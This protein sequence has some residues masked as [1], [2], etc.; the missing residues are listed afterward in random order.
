MTWIKSFFCLF[1]SLALIIWLSLSFSPSLPPS[2]CFSLTL[3]PFFFCCDEVLALP[4]A[5]RF[6]ISMDGRVYFYFF[7]AFLLPTHRLAETAPGHFVSN[8]HSLSKEKFRTLRFW[9]ASAAAPVLC[10]SCC[11]WFSVLGMTHEGVYY[12]VYI[13]LCTSHKWDTALLFTDTVLSYCSLALIDV[14][15]WSCMSF[16]HIVVF[17]CGMKNLPYLSATFSWGH[18]Y[19]KGQYS[20]GFTVSL[21]PCR[22]DNEH[23]IEKGDW[24]F[25]LQHD[26]CIVPPLP[27]LFL[28]LWSFYRKW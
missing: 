5:R 10:L 22:S 7:F 13:T 18:G 23:Y 15:M 19:A 28:L 11:R 2:L 17:S 26:L 21:T 6:I 1:L 4:H 3:M 14:I 8:S 24:P 9:R 16:T 20:C 25:T 12:A 27:V